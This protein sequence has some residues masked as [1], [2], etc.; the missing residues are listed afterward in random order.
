[1]WR[2]LPINLVLLASCAEVSIGFSLAS[3]SP[4]VTTSIR[5]RVDHRREPR[6][7]DNNP[8]SSQRSRETSG[9]RIVAVRQAATDDDDYDRR[10][11]GRGGGGGGGG[12]GG[13]GT[14]T[15]NGVDNSAMSF[16]RKMGRVGGAAN[17]DFATALGLDE[18]PSGGTKSAH[19]VGG[20]KNVRKSKAAY[21]PCTISGVI[22]DMS[23]P[24]PFTSSGSQWQGITDRVMGGISNGSLSR[25][26]IGG[27]VANVLRGNVSMENGGGFIQMATDLSLDPSASLFVDATKY[28]GVE[29]DVYCEGRDVEERFNVHLRTPAC[30]RQNSSYR[31]T[32]A[33]PPGQWTSV[34][35]PWSA[36]EG[37]GPGADVIPFVPSLRRLGVVSIGEA[38]KVIL[39]V[40]KVGFYN[41]I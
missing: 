17:M 23:D 41:V 36:F 9:R 11:D 15:K 38:R 32:F 14:S 22:D 31:F 6:V 19:H 24:F 7:D 34:R 20:F 2:T 8:H 12:E 1:M 27:K 26:T 28:D 37:Y 3:S 18:S 10:E 4:A 16:L 13:G 39:A 40:G 21:V 29:L 35:V 33:I 5:R 30:E 25:E